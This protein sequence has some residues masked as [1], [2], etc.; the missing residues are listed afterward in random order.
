MSARRLGIR[1][2]TADERD[3]W[4]LAEFRSFQWRVIGI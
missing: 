3:Y 4:R 1:V 2:L